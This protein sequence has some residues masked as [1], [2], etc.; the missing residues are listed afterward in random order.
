M[1][2]LAPEGGVVAGET[3]GIAVMIVVAMTGMTGIAEGTIGIV[4]TIVDAGMIVTGMIVTAEMT[5]GMIAGATAGM[6]AGRIA[7]M[8]VGMKGRMTEGK[9]VGEN[10]N[11]SATVVLRRSRTARIRSLRKGREKR[12]V[13][14]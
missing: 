10:V 9:I 1:S 11:V 13:Q 14:R 8:T 5:A 3:T 6:T 2:G 4:E 7:G 12:Q